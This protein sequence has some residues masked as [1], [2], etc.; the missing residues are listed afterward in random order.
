M[1]FC[2][3]FSFSHWSVLPTLRSAVL[4]RGAV[5]AAA[6]MLFQPLLRVIYLSSSM[7]LLYIYIEF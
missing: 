7:S 5:Y 4:R 6:T 2:Q 3:L 1:P